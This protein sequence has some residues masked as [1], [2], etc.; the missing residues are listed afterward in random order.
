MVENP[1]RRYVICPKCGS[2]SRR[3]HTNEDIEEAIKN[4]KGNVKEITKYNLKKQWICSE[5]SYVFE[6][7]EMDI[8]KSFTLKKLI[9]G[10]S[11][12][13]IKEIVAKKLREARRETR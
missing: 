13:E 2:G 9:E 12:K 11:E 4:L 1:I 8:A 7:S 10:K 5:C 3:I 6:L